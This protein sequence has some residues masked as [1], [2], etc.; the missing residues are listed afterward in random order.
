MDASLLVHIDSDKPGD[1]AVIASSAPVDNMGTR[2][3]RRRRRSDD[4]DDDGVI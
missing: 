3:K 2:R 1:E 4:D